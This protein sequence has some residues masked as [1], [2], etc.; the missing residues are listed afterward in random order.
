VFAGGKSLLRSKTRGGSAR[1]G[2]VEQDRG[3]IAVAVGNDEV[4][5]AVAVEVGRRNR[6][7]M[8]AS[9]RIL[10]GGKARRSCGRSIGGIQRNQSSTFLAGVDQVGTAVAVEIS[11]GES[12]RAGLGLDR[13]RCE[14]QG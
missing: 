14:V 12:E 1:G 9:G 10:L 6:A 5:P 7:R 13:L 11:G 3:G 8:P 2:R 4:G